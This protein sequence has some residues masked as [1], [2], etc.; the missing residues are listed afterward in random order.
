MKTLRQ[1]LIAVFLAAQFAI[2]GN[3]IEFSADIR[4]FTGEGVVYRQLLS[5][6]ISKLFRICR[7][8]DGRAVLSEKSFTSARR[9]RISPLR[10]SKP[11]QYLRRSSLTTL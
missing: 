8:L 11:S 3:P 6:T 10:K 5:K 4:E 2:A 7:P 1:T 9:R